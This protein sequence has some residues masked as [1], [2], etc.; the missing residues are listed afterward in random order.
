MDVMNILGV[1]DRFRELFDVM[2][3]EEN[4]CNMEELRNPSIVLSST[5]NDDSWSEYIVI[6]LINE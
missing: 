3:Y 2:G 4:M 5:F 1:V 6:C